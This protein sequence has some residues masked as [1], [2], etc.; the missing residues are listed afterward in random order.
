M[1]MEK[2]QIS[3]FGNGLKDASEEKWNIYSSLQIEFK[4]Y[5]NRKENNSLF[6]KLKYL[7]Y[8]FITES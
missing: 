5:V 3:I 1:E 2:I 8:A 6:N 4:K 7:C